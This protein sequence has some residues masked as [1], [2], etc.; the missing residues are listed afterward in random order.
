LDANRRPPG[1]AAPSAAGGPPP[2]ARLR[3]SHGGPR[4]IGQP[5]AA[6]WPQVQYSS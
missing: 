5:I 3:G 1:R 4:G 6:L 2:G